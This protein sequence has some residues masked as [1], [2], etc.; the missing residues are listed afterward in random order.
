[1]YVCQRTT[2]PKEQAKRDNLPAAITSPKV[3]SVVQKNCR[4]HLLRL[5]EG[6]PIAV[7]LVLWIYTCMDFMAVFYQLEDPVEINSSALQK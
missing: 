6:I 5:F 4:K 2:P 1:M 3:E 7:H